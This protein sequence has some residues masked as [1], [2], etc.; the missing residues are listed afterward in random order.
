M[1]GPCSVGATESCR[2]EPQPTPGGADGADGDFVAQ[3]LPALLTQ[4]AAHL[5]GDFAEE[6]RAAGL[7]V[8]EWR[9]LAILADGRSVPLGLL[10]RRAATKQPT[11]TRMIDRMAQQGLVQREADPVDRRQT[12][13]R[14]TR[15]GH[16]TVGDLISLA[17]RHQQR[18]RELFGEV[19]WQQLVGL[20]RALMPYGG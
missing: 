14:I 8:L 4:A 16:A 13:L 19:R 2:P 10:A 3:Y 7:S 6:V 9:V 15:G 17:Q 18:Q 20:L 12:L 5:V 1:A 11:L